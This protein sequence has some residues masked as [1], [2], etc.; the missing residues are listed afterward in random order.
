MQDPDFGYQ[1]FARRDEDQTQVF[2]VQVRL[3]ALPAGGSP[4]C[5]GVVVVGCPCGPERGCPSLAE[6]LGGSALRGDPS[7]K[8]WGGKRPP[9]V[10]KNH[11]RSPLGPL[12]VNME[13]G[14]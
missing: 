6:P 14:G 13:V 12:W 8:G 2:R 9:S 4:C 1:D 3:L 11:C 10:L 7:D 5:R